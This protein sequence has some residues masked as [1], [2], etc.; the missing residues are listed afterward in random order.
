VY[1]D[2]LRS[3]L[4]DGAA[5]A[6]AGGGV[7]ALSLRPLAAAEGTSTS[8][9]YAMFGGKAGLVAAVVASAQDSFIAAQQASPPTGDAQA[10]LHALG[11][12]YRV[13][14]LANPTL[15]TVMFGGRVVPDRCA[16]NPADEREAEAIGAL[17]A[18]VERL[19]RQGIFRPVGVEVITLSIWASVHGLVSLEIAGLA[20]SADGVARER[21]DAHLDATRRGWLA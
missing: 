14:A 7:D 15:Y 8:A 19:V 18:I 1:D 4:I 21:Y 20:P 2:R 3:R 6:L 16:P 11:H 10:D 12:A 17:L 9:V 5:A 13:W